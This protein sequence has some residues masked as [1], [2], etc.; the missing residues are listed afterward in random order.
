MVE[1][2][3]ALIAV[4]NNLQIKNDNGANQYYETQFVDLVK[5]IDDLVNKD[6]NRLLRILYRVDVS[7]E[8]LKLRLDQNKDATFTSVEVIAQL[9]FEIEQEKIVSRAKYSGK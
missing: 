7:E 8:K 1:N 6:F 4:S 9:L 5:F 3:K 2:N